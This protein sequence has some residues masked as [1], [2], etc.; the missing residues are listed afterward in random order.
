V[1]Y[2]AP[3]ESARSTVREYLREQHRF[4]CGCALCAL[5]DHLAGEVTMDGEERDKSSD[6]RVADAEELLLPLLSG[7][8]AGCGALHLNMEG[9]VNAN[10]GLM[11]YTPAA[12]ASSAIAK[13]ASASTVTAT[14][15]SIATATASASD[16]VSALAFENVTAIENEAISDA[17]GEGDDVGDSDL[18]ALQS[19]V[20]GNVNPSRRYPFYI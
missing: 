6:R 1:C 4:E 9:F 15:S 11:H 13:V 8:M 7:L 20:R 14:T 2:C 18:V 12:A 5:E 17:P 10:M 16:P 3:V 19:E